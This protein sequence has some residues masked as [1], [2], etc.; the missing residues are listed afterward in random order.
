M[1]KPLQTRPNLLH[2]AGKPQRTHGSAGRHRPFLIPSP[3]HQEKGGKKT[4]APAPAGPGRVAPHGQ[5]EGGKRITS[6]I[7]RRG[8]GGGREATRHT[9]PSEAPAALRPAPLASPPAERRCVWVR[10]QERTRLLPPQTLASRPR[11]RPALP[12]GATGA[13][14]PPLPAPHTAARQ[15]SSSS[16]EGGGGRGHT[17]VDRDGPSG[18][19]RRGRH[20]CG[21][22]DVCGGRRGGARTVAH[23][24]ARS[25]EKRETQGGGESGA[26]VMAGRDAAHLAAGASRR[27]SEE[28]SRARP[29]KGACWAAG[30]G[31]ACQQDDAAEGRR[32]EM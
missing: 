22:M 18:E 2:R 6:G 31:S 15:P 26:A 14:G 1:P 10:T 5:R 25:V 19:R 4:S 21:G 17:A 30:A 24:H 3:Q 7:P 32:G 27:G 16:R 11:P 28:S 9:R 13:A 20:R 23:L 8:G 29:E 12:A